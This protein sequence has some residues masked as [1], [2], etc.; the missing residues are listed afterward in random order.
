MLLRR[1]KHVYVCAAASEAIAAWEVAGDA[2][3]LLRIQYAHV[4]ALPPLPA[5]LKHF[6]CFG[7]T[8]LPDLPATLESLNC[9]GCAALTA[10]PDL[11]AALRILNCRGCTALADTFNLP[12]SLVY[13][14][15]DAGLTLSDACPSELGYFNGTYGHYSCFLVWR[16]LVAAQHAAD[17]RRVAAC[18]P[19]LALLFV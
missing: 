19:P 18:L 13:F 17:R 5:A 4:I 14:Y 6:S 2:E 7:C 16:W 12:T 11:P 1:E 9:A 3:A 15:S 10:L 8:A